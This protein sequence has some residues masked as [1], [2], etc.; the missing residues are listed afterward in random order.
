MM[1]LWAVS[2][3]IGLTA[4]SIMNA[5]NVNACIHA[6]SPS[7]ANSPFH[8]ARTFTPPYPI[9]TH[10]KQHSHN[11]IPTRTGARDESSGRGRGR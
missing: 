6:L 9:K 10:N 5:Y 4:Y 8:S 2:L 7:T 3:S 1:D 11:T